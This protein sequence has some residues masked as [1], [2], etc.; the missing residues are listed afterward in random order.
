M[1]E[2]GKL[3]KEAKSAIY[4]TQALKYKVGETVR[5]WEY[6]GNKDKQ[7]AAGIHVHAFRNHCLAWKDKIKYNYIR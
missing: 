3:Y 2:N 7:C 5:P 1:D 6:D 4:E